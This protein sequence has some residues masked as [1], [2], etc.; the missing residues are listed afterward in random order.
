MFRAEVDFHTYEEMLY[1]LKKL[2]EAF[3]MTE[4]LDDESLSTHVER[5]EEVH[6]N[7][8]YISEEMKKIKAVWRLDREQAQMMT[9]EALLESDE[10][11]RSLLG[12][13]QHISC[14]DS[15]EF[16]ELIKPYV[17]SSP[18]PEGF[19]VWPL[20]KHVKLYVKSD[21]LKEGITLVDLPGLSDA[22][23]SRARVAQRS[24]EQLDTTIIVTRSIRAIDEK[25]GVDLMNDYQA[26]QMQA[27]GTFKKKQFCVV[28][29]QMDE[30]DVEGFRIGSEAAKAN[31]SLQRDVEEIER[32]MNEE[33][34]TGKELKGL[35]KRTEAHERNLEKTSRRLKTLEAK[36][37]VKRGPKAGEWPIYFA[38]TSHLTMEQKGNIGRNW[39]PHKKGSKH[40]VC[41]S[42]STEEA[43][44]NF[45]R[46]Y[47]S[48][49]SLWRPV[50]VVQSGPAFA[51]GMSTSPRESRAT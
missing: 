39:T 15:M 22:V 33:C 41:K 51:C 16:A 30:I 35:R 36:E 43:S 44:I 3:G 14:A 42:L 10:Y 20:V 48:S 6:N 19:E 45:I 29:S 2:D 34:S 13:T 7:E 28:A 37:Y 5:M 32:L 38:A 21:M 31:V 40:Y 4:N 50:M 23:E 49:K 12:S 24:F 25:T 46:I 9:P 27:N 26:L 1:D 11:V 8:A 17:D 18:I 47:M